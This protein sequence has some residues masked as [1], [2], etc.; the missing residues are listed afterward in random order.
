MAY[1]DSEGSSVDKY[2]PDT[3]KM[4]SQVDL[5]IEDKVAQALSEH[6]INSTYACGGTIKIRQ[7]SAT[8][9]SAEPIP[10]MAQILRRSR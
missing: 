1:S 8:A 3:K 5:S 9:F 7:S 4:K 2:I 6:L 10:A